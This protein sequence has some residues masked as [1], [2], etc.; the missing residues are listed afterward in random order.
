[1]KSFSLIF[2]SLGG[3]IRILGGLWLNFEDESDFEVKVTIFGHRKNHLALKVIVDQIEDV[4]EGVHTI[5]PVPKMGQKFELTFNS[6]STFHLHFLLPLFEIMYIAEKISLLSSLS[7]DK[8]CY[9]SRPLLPKIATLCSRSWSFI[10]EN[11][12]SD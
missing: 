7:T 9:L 8:M 4:P 2:A 6:L 5:A 3:P 10:I 1:M 11:I 12:A